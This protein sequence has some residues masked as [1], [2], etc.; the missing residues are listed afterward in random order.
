ME[1]KLPPILRA[2]GRAACVRPA[3]AGAFGGRQSHQGKSQKP[4]SLDSREE[5][6]R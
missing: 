5:G 4:C 6:N 3:K 1:E 2:F